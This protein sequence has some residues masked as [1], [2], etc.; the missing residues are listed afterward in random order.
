MHKGVDSMIELM[1]DK[2]HCCGCS[3]CVNICPQKAIELIEDEEGFDYPVINSD[4]CV[5][6]GACI[7]ACGFHAVEE[8]KYDQKYYEVKANNDEIRIRSRSGGVFFLISRKVINS[9]G[10]VYGVAQKGNCVFYSRAESIDEVSQMQG[11]KYVECPVADIF[12][13]V[14]TDVKNGNLVLFSGTACR[15]SGLLSFLRKRGIE[16]TKKLITIDIVCHGVPSH[17]IYREYINFLEDK[18]HGL[19]EKF[20]FRDKSYGWNTHVETF[21]INNKSRTNDIYSGLFY[22]NRFLRPSCEICPFASYNR[23]ADITIADFVGSEKVKNGFNDNKGI[24][25]IMV[26]TEV[27]EHW[28]SMITDECM[29]FPLSKELTEQPNLKH[30]SKF[31][32]DRKEVWEYYFANGFKKTL[33]QYGRND[34]PHRMKWLLIDF[35]KLKKA[36]KEAKKNGGL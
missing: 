16:Y 2:K 6:C 13:Y 12:N 36:K 23:P 19:V 32:S 27:G 26:N 21:L 14:A 4:K 3:S 25:M 1:I 31:A 28:Y 11:S 9:N 17:K 20:D 18:Y 15:I 22:S 29:V 5:E 30:P 35:P 8:S 24:S 33:K 7:S 10:I 34:L